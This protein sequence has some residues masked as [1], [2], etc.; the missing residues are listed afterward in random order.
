[1]GWQ[2][3]LAAL[4]GVP[5]PAVPVPGTETTTP[6]ERHLL[7]ALAQDPGTAFTAEVRTSW[8][9]LR[10]R[11]AAGLTLALV[12]HEQRTALLAEWVRTGG[13]AS[14]FAASEAEPLLNFLAAR[15]PPR[16]HAR[17]VCAFEL[18]V[19]RAHGGS[20]EVFASSSPGP[21]ARIQRARHATHVTFC[22]DPALILAAA[23]GGAPSPPRDDQTQD[24]LLAPGIVGLWRRC[25]AGEAA[26]WTA[27]ATPRTLSHLRADGHDVELMG[28]LLTEGVL[29]IATDIGASARGA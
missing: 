4:V 11:R 1:M 7:R 23:A 21:F 15:L 16:S 19:H 24:L 28:R 26:L 17:S 25:D 27:C 20:G 2:M 10:A 3:E 14:A 13:G 5:R 6:P 22:G 12:P 9:W 29:A 8:C 18:G